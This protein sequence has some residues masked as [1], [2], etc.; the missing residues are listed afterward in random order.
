ICP[1]VVAG[2][3]AAAV[4]ALETS[5]GNIKSGVLLFASFGDPAAGT[6]FFGAARR[7]GAVFVVASGKVGSASF[8]VDTAVTSILPAE[9]NFSDMIGLAGDIVDGGA[10]GIGESANFAVDAAATSLFPAEFIF[11]DVIALA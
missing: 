8:P 4:T 9:F 6:L 3:T 5:S 2:A 11:S 7:A 10:F 1:A